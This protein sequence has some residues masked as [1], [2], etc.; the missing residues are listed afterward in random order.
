MF[1]LSISLC[2]RFSP[3]DFSDCSCV[4]SYFY[5][6]K[7][8]SIAATLIYFIEILPYH[9]EF[10]P[11]FTFHVNTRTNLSFVFVPSRWLTKNISSSAAFVALFPTCNSE[12][13]DT[14]IVPWVLV[15]KTSESKI[16]MVR[17]RVPVWNFSTRLAF[18]PLKY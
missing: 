16:L 2:G 6:H 10:Y 18:A 9:T 12:K 17:V 11:A 1:N 3:V 7:N 14:C 4:C 8:T 15:G 5:F 13:F